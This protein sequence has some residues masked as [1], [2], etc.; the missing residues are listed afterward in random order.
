[1]KHRALAA[2]GAAL[3]IAAS[4]AN[5]QAPVAAPAQPLNATAAHE[6]VANAQAMAVKPMAANVAAI[7]AQLSPRLS[8]PART[9]VESE[10]KVIAGGQLKAHEMVA[11]ARRDVTQR[12]AGQGLQNMDV[13]ALVACVMMQASEDAQN[14]LKDQLSQLQ[15][16]S[17]QKKQLRAEENAMKQAKK[18]MNDQIADLTQEQQLQ[19]QRVMDRMTQADDAMSNVIKKLKDTDSQILRNLK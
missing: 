9:W 11:T 4:S 8:A 10:A 19:M 16:A 2:T 12:F 3:V 17:S 1:M 14:E 15:K 6:T 5:A 13:E 7:H 18:N